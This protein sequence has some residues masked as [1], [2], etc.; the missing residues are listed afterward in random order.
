MCDS[1]LIA[2][3]DPRRD[4]RHL[5]VELSVSCSHQQLWDKHQGGRGIG[6]RGVELWRHSLSCRTYF[7]CGHRKPGGSW[8][9]FVISG[10]WTET[11]PPPPKSSGDPGGLQ[12]ADHTVSLSDPQQHSREDW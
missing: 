7:S 6:E 1:S 9:S 8:E 11:F 2:S 10:A 4:S 3:A 12:T 5:A